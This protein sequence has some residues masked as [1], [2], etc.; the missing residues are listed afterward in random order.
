MDFVNVIFGANKRKLKAVKHPWIKI[1]KI[2]YHRAVQ[3]RQAVSVNKQVQP[4]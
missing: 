2:K 4:L 3:T 1:N